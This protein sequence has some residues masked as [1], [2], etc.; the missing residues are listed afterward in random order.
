MGRENP[1]SELHLT[2]QDAPRIEY[3]IFRDS[4]SEL[5][6]MQRRMNALAEAGWIYHSVMWSDDSYIVVLME[7]TVC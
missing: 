4:L 6:S 3:Q 5:A 2:I 1:Y 7:R